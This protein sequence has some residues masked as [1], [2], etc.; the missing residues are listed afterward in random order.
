[1]YEFGHQSPVELQL[2]LQRDL[3]GHMPADVDLSLAG[4]DLSDASAAAMPEIPLVAPD[5]RGIDKDEPKA[6]EA[7]HEETG[8]QVTLTE[9]AT[10]LGALST[11][12]A[13]VMEG[14]PDR[15]SK[16]DNAPHP[17]PL[18]AE[19]DPAPGAVKG[20]LR[21][22]GLRERLDMP[23]G[24]GVSRLR[25]EM[26]AL[27]MGE[28]TYRFSEHY[29]DAFAK[30]LTAKNKWPLPEEYARVLANNQDRLTPNPTI[31]RIFA[32]T[33]EAKQAREVTQV[34]WERRLSQ[35]VSGS[36]ADAQVDAVKFAELVGVN[37]QTI[38]GWR[39]AGLL[40]VDISSGRRQ[41]PLASLQPFLRWQYPGRPN[42]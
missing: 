24:G 23:E 11:T 40:S 5:G 41:I 6:P 2:F 32:D 28:R 34:V 27:V 21:A 7:I 12:K 16:G 20:L 19:E 13:I 15:P 18:Q 36:E 14:N 37:E 33:S 39:R 42:E 17:A 30:W 25:P 31:A 9:A 29:V 38:D 26:L 22:S 4:Q 35:L 3:R 1:M 8:R 10:S